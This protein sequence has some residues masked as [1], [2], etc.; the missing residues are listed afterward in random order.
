MAV[1]FRLFR[2]YEALVLLVAA[3][4]FIGCLISPPSLMDDV[5]AVQASIAHNM[6]QSGDWVTPHL[7]GVK[8]MEK[9][10]LKYWLIAIFFKLFGVRDTVARLPLA[11]INV[12]LCWLT[13]RIG[14]WAFGAKSGLFAGLVLA[15]S[16]G[17]FLF[18]RVLISDSALTFTIALA[19]WAF[20]RAVDEE[21]SHPRTWGLVFWAST[22]VGVLFKGLI[23][24]LFPFAAA[25]LYLVFTRQVVKAE[26]WRRLTPVWGCLLFFAIAA[27]WHILAALQ[28][29]PIAYFAMHSGPGEYHGFFW[30]YFFNEHILRF[31]NLR[32]P[33]DYD[34]V[35]RLY[36]WLF[37]LLWLFP[38]SFYFPAV[39]RLAYRGTDRAARTRL[40]ALCSIGFL[41]FFF[42]FS[43]TQEYYSMPA[44]PAIALLLGCALDAEDARAMRRVRWGNSSLMVLLTVASGAIV[45][46]LFRVWN[47]PTPG[48]ISSALTQHPE[49]YK[50]SMGHMG[51]LT[52]NSFAYLRPPLL[53]ALMA[54]LA[55]VFGLYF[56]KRDRR[57][58]AVAAMMVVF[59]HAARAAMATFDPY[60]SSRPLA[61]ALLKAPPGQLLAED[62]YYTFSSV[63]FYTNRKALFH[64]GRH[65]NLEYGSNSPGAP[66]IF[67]NDQD[68]VSWWQ[69]SERCYLLVEGPSL[70]GIE[71]LIGHDYTVVTQ[72]GGKFLL[73]SQPITYLAGGSYA[74]HP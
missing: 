35:P 40:F 42:T 66:H 56:W 9:P 23:A 54:L 2:R 65:N 24:A 13:A 59:F 22:G 11:I 26:I 5:D 73:T 36:F 39:T 74:H 20:L 49:L 53:I 50:L 32:Y 52:L 71:K 6:L 4:V 1:S 51:D 30:F 63:F 60:L 3:L 57:V 10:P 64:N 41:M 31:L 29:P 14:F 38:W 25:C 45:F 8:Y 12:L 67:I 7:N 33:R 43:S 18:T 19:M 55:G 58:F 21:E 17:L 27:P 61:E 28:N 16:L 69:G 72:S 15:T 34:T 37:H 70:Q 68:L 47:L 48:D 46:I 44:Y 62:A